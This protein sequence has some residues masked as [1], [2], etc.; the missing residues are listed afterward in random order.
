LEAQTDDSG[1]VTGLVFE[2]GGIVHFSEDEQLLVRQIDNA[3][4]P[5]KVSPS[6]LYGE[7]ERLFDL[8]AMHPEMYDALQLGTISEDNDIFMSAIQWYGDFMAG[9]TTIEQFPQK[10]LDPYIE[11]G[12]DGHPAF[13]TYKGHK[14]SIQEIQR[15][16]ELEEV[17]PEKEKVVDEQPRFG[18]KAGDIL[19][20]PRLLDLFAET[21]PE[22]EKVVVDPEVVDPEKEKVVVVPTIHEE[23]SKKEET[24]YELDVER[25]L[26]EEHNVEIDFD[27]ITPESFPFLAFTSGGVPALYGDPD[28]ETKLGLPDNI[29]AVQASNG[30]IHSVWTPPGMSEGYHAKEAGIPIPAT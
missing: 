21:D 12:A 3:P 28:L 23:P 2:D 10:L 18:G 15:V 29:R 9:K 25:Y 16:L 11:H 4:D 14:F 6:D 22:K 8:K 30:V 24:E 1:K 17:L 27:N 5:Y 13:V 19:D 7:T 26:R 20:D